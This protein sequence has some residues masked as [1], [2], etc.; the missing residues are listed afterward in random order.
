MSIN[1]LSSHLIPTISH[2]FTGSLYPL[3]LELIEHRIHH[4]IPHNVPLS[5][6][7]ANLNLHKSICL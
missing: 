4:P 2:K 6:F 5:S 3:F 1:G 7:F